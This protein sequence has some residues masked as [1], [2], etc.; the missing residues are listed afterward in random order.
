MNETKSVVE[1]SKHASVGCN[2]AKENVR[3]R[4]E[5]KYGLLTEETNK[6]KKKRK[7]WGFFLLWL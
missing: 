1:C 6:K 5:I 3:D 7:M 4:N 2:G